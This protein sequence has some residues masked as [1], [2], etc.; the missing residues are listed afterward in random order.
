MWSKIINITII[1]YTEKYRSKIECY[2]ITKLL[3]VVRG[4]V[5]CVSALSCSKTILNK[6]LQILYFVIIDLLEINKCHMFLLIL[7]TKYL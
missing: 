5:E 3:I 7:H 1:K 4:M 6:L 2:K